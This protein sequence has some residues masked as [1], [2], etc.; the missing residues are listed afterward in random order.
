[1]FLRCGCVRSR[2]C[3]LAGMSAD[4]S[5]NPAVGLLW[6]SSRLQGMGIPF[7]VT[8]LPGRGRGQDAFS[9]LP[10]HRLEPEGV[11]GCV[12]SGKLYK[13]INLIRFYHIMLFSK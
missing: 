7:P 4:V 1:M 10:S 2:M 3:T 8:A 12:L 13:Y 5:G 11:C 6:I 9:L